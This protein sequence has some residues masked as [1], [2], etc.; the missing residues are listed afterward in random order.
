MAL[1]QY[2]RLDSYLP[3]DVGFSYDGVPEAGIELGAFKYRF[4]IEIHI[5]D[6]RLE[7]NTPATGP[8]Q[9]YLT[10]DHA[11]IAHGIFT[12]ST[13]G[14]FQATDPST[15]VYRTS[16]TV[17][18]LAPDSMGEEETLSNIRATIAGM[19]LATIGDG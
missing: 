14:F 6:C 11:V 18:L 12:D 5:N 8:K 15:S 17:R 1:D 9:L 3:Y 2:I 16:G 7:A 19:R 4:D 13:A 10:V